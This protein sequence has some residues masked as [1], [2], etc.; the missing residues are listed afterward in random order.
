MIID[1][2][3]EEEICHR[4]RNGDSILTISNDLTIGERVIKRILKDNDVVIRN[5]NASKGKRRI[6]DIK[7]DI[8]TDY[9]ENGFSIVNLS[10]KYEFSIRT[11][12][13][14]FKEN[15]VIIRAKKCNLEKYHPE[16]LS[17]YRKGYSESDISKV[18]EVP[19]EYIIRIL[20]NNG[21]RKKDFIHPFL[22]KHGDNIIT[23][24]KAG[25]KIDHISKV[26]KINEET[27]LKILK[28]RR[29]VIE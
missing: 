5:S 22:Q 21:V 27:I 9:E 28:T 26:F 15:G 13:K 4:Y 17:M 14:L 20:D 23:M 11:I 24:F 3:M 25:N 29:V 6:E 19:K 7:D 10:K 8:I 1:A 12:K 16:I 18:Y 2:N